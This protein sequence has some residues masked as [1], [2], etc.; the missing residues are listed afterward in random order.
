MKLTLHNISKSFDSLEVLCNYSLSLESGH[1]Y[2]L[3]GPSGC[4]KT[5]L[6]RILMG[7]EQADHGSVEGLSKPV[8]APFSRKTVCVKHL[9]LWKML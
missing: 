1:I 4:G 6:L 3:M 8:S 5:T 9:L 7:L 2:C